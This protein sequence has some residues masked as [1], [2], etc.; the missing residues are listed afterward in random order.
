MEQELEARPFQPLHSF[1]SRPALCPTPHRRGPELGQQGRGVGRAL[2][3]DGGPSPTSLKGDHPAAPY[4]E[5]L[6]T[7]RKNSQC[8]C[9]RKIPIT[10]TL[11]PTTYKFNTNTN[12]LLG[13]WAHTWL[14]L[15]V[16]SWAGGRKGEKSFPYPEEK[17]GGTSLRTMSPREG[18][19]RYSPG[20]RGTPPSW[21]LQ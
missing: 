10:L 11:H 8:L 15:A 18:P 16:G 2:P 4:L 14:L 20:T 6:R 5:S 21:Q 1:R 13:F 19:Q 7:Q 9:W 12:T 3:S 17:S